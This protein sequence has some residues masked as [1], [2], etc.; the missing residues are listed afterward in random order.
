MRW[1]RLKKPDCGW[2]YTINPDVWLVCHCGQKLYTFEQLLYH[3][4]Q[5]HSS[6]IR[7]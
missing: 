4:K 6:T 5:S 3:D 2:P 1:Y 7:R